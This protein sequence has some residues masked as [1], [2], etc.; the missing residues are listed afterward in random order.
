MSTA[1]RSDAT[2][3]VDI[4]GTKVFGVLVDGEGTVVGEARVSTPQL[5]SD[6][7]ASAETAGHD[8][9]DAVVAVVEALRAEADGEHPPS[10]V[11]IGAPGMVDASGILRFAP[12]LPSASGADL[13]QLVS[14]RMPGVF[15]DVANDANCAAIAECRFGALVG[16]DHGLMVTLGTGIGVGLI[17]DGRIELGGSGFAG[18]A[19][20]IIVNPSGPA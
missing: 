20:H 17:V 10:R 11:G 3:G 9:A 8:V 13:G 1:D 15:V 6:G 4:G 12:N 16:V 14:A 5:E 2:I 18:E 7:A 19:G